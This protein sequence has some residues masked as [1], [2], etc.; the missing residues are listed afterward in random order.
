MKTALRTIALLLV[1]LQ[2]TCG[3]LLHF[4]LFWWAN[5]VVTT[6]S[7]IVTFQTSKREDA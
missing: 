1:A 3:F 5:M 7:C 2:I 4:S 6:G